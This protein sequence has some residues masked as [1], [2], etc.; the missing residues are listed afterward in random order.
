MQKFV[1]GLLIFL[2]FGCSSLKVV[3]FDNPRMNFSNF[4]EYTLKR[5]M[6]D[7]QELT[8]EGR[9][10]I[11]KFESAIKAEMEARGY[12]LTYSPDLE[13]SYDIMSSRQQDTNI[14]R[15]PFYYNPWYYGNTYGVSQTNYTESIVIVEL[16]EIGSGKTAWQGSLDLRYTRNSKKTDMII[17]EAVKNIFSA[18]PYLAGSNKKIEREK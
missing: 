5:P 6:V 11:E 8:P 9:A 18:Y 16:K 3:S 14:N 13:V 4:E 15:R 7:N 17:P 12:R 10:F 2:N 1:F